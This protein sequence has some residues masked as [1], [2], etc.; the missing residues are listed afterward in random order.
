MHIV[1]HVIA[2]VAGAA[3]AFGFYHREVSIAQRLYAAWVR[4][5]VFFRQEVVAV[6]A[7]FKKIFHLE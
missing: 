6:E 2:F 1:T 3:V 7:E 5:D 4:G